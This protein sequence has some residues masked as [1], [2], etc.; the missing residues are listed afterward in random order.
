MKDVAS[1]MEVL[2]FKYMNKQNIVN[3]LTNNIPLFL[4]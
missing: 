1:N 2:V 3:I 4:L